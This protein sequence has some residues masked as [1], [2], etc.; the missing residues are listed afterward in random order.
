MPR[1]RRRRRGAPSRDTDDAAVDSTESRPAEGRYPE[2]TYPITPASPF[3]R[4][5]AAVID[6]VA[7]F[8]IF[9]VLAVI[10]RGV[11]LSARSAWADLFLFFGYFVLFT[12]LRGQTPGKW[13][14]GIIVVD[15][16][17]RIPGVGVAIPRE[18]V[19]KFV[20]A[21]ALGLGL[22]WLVFD[23]KRQGWHDKIAGTF[24]V[25]KSGAGAPAPFRALW[26]LGERRGGE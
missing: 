9:V 7:L 8:A 24:V 17:G 25:T 23:G 18:M 14:A 1:R 13:A 3:L 5:Y 19:G 2:T 4:V 6:G 11:F 20:S 15:R 26:R 22:I 21:A 16:E 12:G 10:T